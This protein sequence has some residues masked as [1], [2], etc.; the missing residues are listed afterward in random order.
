[1][2]DFLINLA[3][4]IV[5]LIL[6]GVLFLYLYAKRLKGLLIPYLLSVPVG[7]IILYSR[8]IITT[9][10]N[11]CLQSFIVAAFVTIPFAI[12]DFLYCFHWSKSNRRLYVKTCCFC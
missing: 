10:E 7:S 8:G 2:I 11:V 5:S 1:M 12:Y 4:T 9:M 6:C 3:V